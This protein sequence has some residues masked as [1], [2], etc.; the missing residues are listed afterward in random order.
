MKNKNYKYD[1]A[2]AFLKKDEHLANQIN[3]LIYDNYSSYLYSKKLED[4]HNTK[5]GKTFLDVFGKKSKIVVVLYRNKWGTTPWTEIE[6]KVIR[7]RATKEGE[8]FLIIIPLD[9]PLITPKYLPQTQI[10]ADFYQSQALKGP[11]TLLKRN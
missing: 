1:V 3:D 5:P 2:F 6:E 4:I 10:W 11:Q 7:E 9:N 8:D